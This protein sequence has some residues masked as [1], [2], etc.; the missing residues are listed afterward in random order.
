MIIHYRG[1][2]LYMGLWGQNN[3]FVHDARNWLNVEGGMVVHIRGAH[4]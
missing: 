4:L 3:H 1:E 2:P